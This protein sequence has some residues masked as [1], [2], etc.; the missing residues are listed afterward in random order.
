MR[1]L[2]RIKIL[3]VVF[4][5]LLIAAYFSLQQKLTTN[6]I[7]NN[8]QSVSIEDTASIEKITIEKGGEVRVLTKS[9]NSTWL[10]NN[11]YKVRTNVINLLLLGLN[12][13]EIKRPVSEEMKNKTLD[14]LK[15]SGTKVTVEYG[16]QKKSLVFASNENDINTSLLITENSSTPN[17]AYVPGVPGDINNIFKLT[18]QEWRSRELFS[19]KPGE[20]QTLKVTYPKASDNFEIYFQGGNL[21]LKDVAPL[22]SNKLFEYLELYRYVPV[23]SYLPNHD[24]IDS[25]FKTSSYF[26]TIDLVDINSG[27]SN[28]IQI[29]KNGG[30]GK[31]YLGKVASSK[32]AVLVNKEVFD[33]LLVN[34]A[35]FVKSK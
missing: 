6:T 27:K 5:M 11:K 7:K 32:E 2:T 12:Q 24:S 26:A 1:S 8:D 4:V 13:L 22:D 28:S 19:S 9:P 16:G 3:S 34:K 15:R 14:L 33:R 17:I 29:Y 30:N 23:S 31:D 18:E 35:Y 21:I 25:K 10:V 20:I